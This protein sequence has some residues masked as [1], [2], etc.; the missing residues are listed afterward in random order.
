M[1]EFSCQTC[2]DYQNSRQTVDKRA[3]AVLLI[4]VK[5]DFK[6]KNLNGVYLYVYKNQNVTGLKWSGLS[7]VNCNLCFV[8]I[9]VHVAGKSREGI[10]EVKLFTLP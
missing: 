7:G 9:L 3:Q 8:T 6:V 2:S 4:G 10:L 1:P 5:K